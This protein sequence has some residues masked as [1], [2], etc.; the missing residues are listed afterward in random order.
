MTAEI[1]RD[2]RLWR[3]TV[4]WSAVSGAVILLLL[5]CDYRNGTK[6]DRE[7]WLSYSL[8]QSGDCV[9]GV[10][11]SDLKSRH[12]H[13]GTDRKTIEELLGP[14]DSSASMEN[15]CRE[16][17][18][19]MCSGFGMDFDGLVVC[20]DGNGKLKDSYTVQH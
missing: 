15:A 1:E 13:R 6:F 10:M 20:Y 16:Y 14:D 19:G 7:T 12:L 3:R 2:E 18:L 4:I 17:L 11:V 8:N 5:R 9:R